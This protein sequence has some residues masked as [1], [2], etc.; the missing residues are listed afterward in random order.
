MKPKLGALM[1]VAGL[2]AATAACSSHVGSTNPA[3]AATG[4]AA[5]DLGYYK[6]KTITYVVP[7]A[8]GTSSYISAQILAPVAAAYLHA[9][10]NLVSVPAGNGIAGQNQVNASR[11]DGLTLGT[12][13]TNTDLQSVI[14]QQQGTNFDI[15][16][17]TLIAGE[18]RSPSLIVSAPSSPFK[19]LEDA[20]NSPT[21]FTVIDDSGGSDE[22]L[23]VIFGAYK[24]KAKILSGYADAGSVVQGFLR[25]DAPI[26]QQSLADLQGALEG[27]K[28][29]P[30]VLNAPI[31]P[32]TT[33]YN[34]LKNT[35]AI[36]DF[37]TSHQPPTTEGQQAMSAL[38]AQFTNDS[39]NQV[40]F[41]APGT[42]PAYAGALRAAF[43]KALQDPTVQQKFTTA[44]LSPGYVSPQDTLTHMNDVIAGAPDIRTFLKYSYTSSS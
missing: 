23:R 39:P 24:A 30:L 37:L 40:V 17:T 13:N 36:G 1:L 35:P 33:D 6:G 11:P 18:L 29:N 15:T 22:Q 31:T 41:A 16:K 44:G 3:A 43:Q 10:I 28:A 14:T 34:L 9:T 38:V 19:T 25:G 32:T 42:P 2:V 26:T 4:S 21:P 27:G 12:L 20:I 8:P 5:P 7:A